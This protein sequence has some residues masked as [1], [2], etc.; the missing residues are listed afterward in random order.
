MEMKK[1]KSRMLIGV[2]GIALGLLLL[3]PPPTHA[4]TTTLDLLLAGQNVTIGDKIFENWRNFSSTVSGGAFVVNPAAVTL[5]FTEVSDS[6]YRIDYQSSQFSV[7]RNQT[8]DTRFTYDVAVVGGIA[9]IH[10]NGLELISFGVGDNTN[11]II[12]IS[13]TI[14]D[15]AGHTI[16]TKLVQD[17]RGVIINPA[18]FEWDPPL[19]FITINKDIGLTGLDLD[20]GGAFL[21]DFDQTFSQIPEPTTL[22]LLGSGLLGAAL[23]RRLRKPKG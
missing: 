22:I 15:A 2:I 9:K 8:Q 17:N 5:V 21:S 18:H 6:L 12:N 20:H 4:L 11:G 23:Y 7:G 1:W 13:E 10:D 14:F 16:G 19:A 3:S